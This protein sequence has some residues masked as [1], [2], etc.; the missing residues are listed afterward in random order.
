MA[1]ETKHLKTF[2]LFILIDSRKGQGI[3]GFKSVQE[4]KQIVS[5]AVN[6]CYMN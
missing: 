1:F 5:T 3:A 2:S 4:G 6:R